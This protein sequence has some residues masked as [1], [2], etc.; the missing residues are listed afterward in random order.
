MIDDHL[1]WNWSA[2]DLATHS[3]EPPRPSSSG[4]MFV[5]FGADGE[6]EVSYRNGINKKLPNPPMPSKMPGQSKPAS[7]RQTVEIKHHPKRSERQRTETN[8]K[9]RSNRPSQSS[10]HDSILDPIAYHSIDITLP[11]PFPAPNRPLPPLPSQNPVNLQSRK[12]YPPQVHAT[13]RTVSTTKARHSSPAPST[14]T[15]HTARDEAEGVYTVI[16]PDGMTSSY[17][18]GGLTTSSTVDPA[19]YAQAA[20]VESQAKPQK[21]QYLDIPNLPHRSYPTA[22][23]RSSPSCVPLKQMDTNKPLPPLP[24]ASRPQQLGESRNDKK[25]HKIAR[26][27]KVL[28]KIE[29][30]R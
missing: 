27:V 20:R 7:P 4:T 17:Q 23:I 21:T 14:T 18:S 29:G 30:R 22:S 5:D 19:A 25:R 2:S 26:F 15:S 16:E 3:P 13:S 1:G 10:R 24:P 28:Q 12:S 8:P 6:V 9:P 11:P